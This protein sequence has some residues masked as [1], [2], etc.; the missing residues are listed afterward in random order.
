MTRQV[1][2]NARS[3][4][5]A[6]SPITARNSRSSAARRR[7]Q[8]SRPRLA[9][10]LAG[11][12]I[13]QL[14]PSANASQ[15]R[16]SGDETG[17]WLARPPART[18]RHVPI[19]QLAQDLVRLSGMSAEEI[20][21]LVGPQRMCQIFCGRNDPTVTNCTLACGDAAFCFYGSRCSGGAGSSSLVSSMQ[22]QRR[23][24][25]TRLGY[26]T[27]KMDIPVTQPDQSAGLLAMEPTAIPMRCCAASTT[28]AAP[29]KRRW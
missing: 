5:P 1:V 27:L 28:S 23:L 10:A 13:V 9:W 16:S 15:V 20:E 6:C 14:A 17:T 7:R 3:A 18:S 2:L 26:A 22:Q 4:S 29:R 19:V 24:E 25:A 12:V 21:K 11:V 8:S